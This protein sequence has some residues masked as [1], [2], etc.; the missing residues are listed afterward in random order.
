M[1]IFFYFNLF[2]H[3]FYTIILLVFEFVCSI[4]L[5]LFIPFIYMSLYSRIIYSELLLVLL[6]LLYA[7]SCCIYYQ[8]YIKHYYY[9]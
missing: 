6:L 2:I 1:N 8:K 3:S 4:Y 9:Y 5:V 7:F